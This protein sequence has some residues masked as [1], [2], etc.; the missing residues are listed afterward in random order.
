MSVTPDVWAVAPSESLGIE[1]L[2]SLNLGP[3]RLRFAPQ[4]VA[5]GQFQAG[6]YGGAQI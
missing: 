6:S 4:S 1:N 2:A 5:R 3:R